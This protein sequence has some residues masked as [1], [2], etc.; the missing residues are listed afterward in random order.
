MIGQMIM[1]MVMLEHTG[2]KSG[3][4]R[5]TPLAAMPDGGGFWLVGSNYGRHGQPA[6]TANL[7]AHPDV[8]VVH[9]GR[10]REL[11]ARLVEG[12]ERDAIWPTLTAFW[13]GYAEYQR[14]NDPATPT[15]RVLRVFR[16]DPR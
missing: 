7:L 11:R 5:T 1:P 10:H 3:L 8:A 14:M 2:A 6:W 12:A 16:L 15:G 9:G 4:P 13:P